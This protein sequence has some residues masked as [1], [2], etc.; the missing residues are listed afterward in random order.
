VTRFFFRQDYDN[1]IT[2]LAMESEL[3][4]AILDVV[5]GPHIGV[6]RTN[7]ISIT[8]APGSIHVIVAT[9]T[10][11]DA[12]KIQSAANTQ[13]IAF[14]INSIAF[15]S[16]DLSDGVVTTTTT[17]LSTESSEDAAGGSEASSTASSRLAI[18]DWAIALIIVII[19][20]IAALVL[21]VI[22]LRRMRRSTYVHHVTM[23]RFVSA[24]L[25]S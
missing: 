15:V 3:R 6:L 7:V 4:V 2:N 16:N 21:L 12:N 19:V 5:S 8:F 1:I 18:P 9:R 10:L 11:S 22:K 24:S 23:L 17:A 25:L 20:V 13:S 14:I